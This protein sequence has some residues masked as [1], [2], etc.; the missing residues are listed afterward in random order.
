MR[1]PRAGDPLVL[2]L[3]GGMGSG[4][5]CVAKELKR[6]GAGVVVAD[7]LGHEALR[8]PEIRDQVIGRW[9]REVLDA[10][11]EVDRRKLGRLVFADPSERAALEALSFPYI[12]RRMQQE[13]AAAAGRPEC[14]LVVLDAAVLL[15]AGWEDLCD[16]VVFV[17]AP[18][19][20]RLRRL[21]EQRGWTAEEVTAR[22][23]AQWPLTDK[24]S[25]ANDVIQN[26]GPVEDLPQQVDALLRRWNVVSSDGPTMAPEEPNGVM[27]V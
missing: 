15:E 18:R 25:R 8:Q 4:K 27:G 13:I 3:I 7:Q 22:E 16:G 26:A 19:V 14:R 21:A 20:E 5:S 24:L 10:G 2:G 17:S 6:R 23:Q 1:V 12:R 11:G 9:G